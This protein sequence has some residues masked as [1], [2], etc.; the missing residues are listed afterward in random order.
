MYK[1][2]RDKG[3]MTGV[4]AGSIVHFKNGLERAINQ[5]E[6]FHITWRSKNRFRCLGNGEAETDESGSG[7]VAIYMKNL[8][9][10]LPSGALWA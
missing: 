10:Y 9:Y 4:Y 6:H 5:G 3:R 2:G 8:D 7:D 1:N